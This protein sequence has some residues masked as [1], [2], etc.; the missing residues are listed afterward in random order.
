MAPIQLSGGVSALG[1]C[2]AMGTWHQHVLD[3]TGITPDFRVEFAFDTVNN[4][5][6]TGAGWFIDDFEVSDLVV[7]SLHQYVSGTTTVIPVGG[8][9]FPPSIDIRGIVDAGPAGAVRLEVE[10]QLVATAFTG[11]PT[12]TATATTGAGSPVVVTYAIPAL[13][14]YH[15][16]ARTVD[17]AGAVTSGWM[18]FGLNAVAAAD[19][20]VAA[21]PLGAGGGGGGGCGATGFEGFLIAALLRLRRRRA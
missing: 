21:V 14:D 13:G 7:S 6:N 17:V 15:W 1:A 5:N 19:F 3:L 16:R 4:V 8:S 10:I 9:T 18:E 11:T 12:L 20:T 2:A